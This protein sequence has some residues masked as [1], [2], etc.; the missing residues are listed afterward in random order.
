MGVLSAETYRRDMDCTFCRKLGWC[1]RAEDE[2]FFV[3]HTD[4]AA[5]DL[6][7]F[8]LFSLQALKQVRRTTRAPKP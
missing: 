8:A 2:R 7:E 4:Q 5:Q 6:T 3:D 1:D